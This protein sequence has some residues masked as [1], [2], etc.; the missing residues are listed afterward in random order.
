MV[1]SLQY[2]FSF[3]PAGFFSGGLFGGLKAVSFCLPP[4]ER[5][6]RVK[7]Y[8][9]ANA[10]KDGHTKSFSEVKISGSIWKISHNA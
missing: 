2:K 5:W 6:S 4:N 9:D 8:G 1:F 10:G 3:L 7:C